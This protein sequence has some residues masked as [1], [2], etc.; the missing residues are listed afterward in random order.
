ME[1]EI[2]RITG[3]DNLPDDKKIKDW[4]GT[5]AFAYWRELEDWINQNYPGIF[6]PQ[7][8]YGGKK[9]GWVLRYKKNKSFCSFVPEKNRFKLLI[10]F[11]A[12]ERAKT[13]KILNTL[14]AGTQKEYKKAETYHDG[15]WLLLTVD[16]V[17]IIDDIKILLA[18][19]RKPKI[20]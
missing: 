8:L 4:T 1:S 15:K 9:H 19:K 5:E 18:L 13:D 12:E 11:G 3:S 14:S 20:L 10:V 17:K 2:T 16:C 7:W 6:N